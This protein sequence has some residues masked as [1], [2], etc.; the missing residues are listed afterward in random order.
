MDPM[1][2]IYLLI[3]QGFY[4]G[5][6]C[7]R[8]TF[9]SR[10]TALIG[11]CVEIPC[12]YHPD[13]GSGASCTVWYWNTY[14]PDPEIL[15]TK[16]SSTVIGEY[17]DRTS[18]VPGNNSCTLRIDPVR[19]GDGGYYYNPGITEDRTINAGGLQNTYVLLSVTDDVN[20]ELYVP[21]RMTEGEATTL[22]CT[23]EHTCRSS[24]P[25]LLWNKP[26]QVHH[27]SVEISGG[28]WRQESELT[29]IPSYLDDGTSVQCTATYPNGQSFHESGTL[30]INDL[31]TKVAVIVLGIGEVMEGSDVT[32]QCNSSS[33]T[34]VNKYEWY[35]GK[36]K[37]KLPDTG[38]KIT[39]MKV[40]RDV[41]PYSCAA[42]NAAGRG[43]SA[44]VE[45]PVLYAATGVHITVKN[46]GEFTK[47]ICD[48][49]S[50]RPD[51]THYTWMKDGSI[52]QD[53][54]GKTLTIENNVENA[55]Q[56]SCIAHN[57]AGDSSSAEIN[58]TGGTM[59]SPVIWG[60]AAGV[61]FLLLFILILF[62]CLRR[63]RKSSSIRGSSTKMSNESEMSKDD[64]HH[65]DNQ[66]SHNAQPPSLRSGPS[67]DV[68]FAGN[69]VAYSNNDGTQPSNEVEYSVIS[70]R[71]PNQAGQNSS[72]AQHDEDVEYATLKC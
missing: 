55:G 68:N 67:V 23:V 72:R 63:K 4:L 2:Q 39:V 36:N 11:S 20:I 6:L 18:L 57:I 49:L 16:D 29:Y 12:T 13:G 1:K 35:K 40:T 42:I 70:H 47:L 25:S 43:E 52:L 45:I 59:F 50:S 10:I 3:C 28:F 21:K 62:C 22:R 37:T 8:W 24:P 26:G 44:L 15:N 27:Q 54:K 65:G 17:R 71:Q 33:K 38:R 51:V 5:S 34:K 64:N 7:Q 14:G 19:R 32:L 66:S 58:H 30:N 9:P 56:Y 53:Q 61:F 31:P 60:S 48:F 69:Q 46:E 41:E